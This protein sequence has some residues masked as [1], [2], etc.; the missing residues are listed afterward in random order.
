[1]EARQSLRNRPAP[2]GLAVILAVS[3]A[4]GI[5]VT[6]TLVVKN[7]DSSTSGSVNAIAPAAVHPAPGTVLRQDNPAA[8]AVQKHEGRSTGNATGEQSQTGSYAP[9]WDAGSVREGH[10]P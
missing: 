2:M 5:A 10:G 6:G 7:L 3:V 9:G 8:A 1:M 4:I